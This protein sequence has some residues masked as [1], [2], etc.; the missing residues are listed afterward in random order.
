ML[1]LSTADT[2][3]HY[4]GPAGLKTIQGLNVA[5]LDGTYNAAAYSSDPTDMDSSAG[6][7]HYTQVSRSPRL[8]SV[9]CNK[10]AARLSAMLSHSVA[11]QADVNRLKDQLQGASGD[12]DLLLTCEWPEN[13]LLSLP[14]GS[15]PEGVNPSGTVCMHTSASSPLTPILSQTPQSSIACPLRSASIV[16]RHM[17][18]FHMSLVLHAARHCWWAAVKTR[19]GGC[20]V[21]QT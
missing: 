4:L 1:A 3:I 9:L 20:Q 12:V 16:C 10:A 14:P 2:N 8:P 6:C 15:A 13:L 5:Y 19:W 21:I 11:M 7:R 18:D 17:H